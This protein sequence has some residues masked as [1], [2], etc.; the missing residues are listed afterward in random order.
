MATKDDPDTF[1]ILLATDNH[2][3]YMEKDPIRG[4]DSFN[5]FEEILKL[6]QERNADLILLG[7]DL[8]HDNKPSRKCLHSTMVLLRKY[9][10]GDRP[11]RVEFLSDQ[12]ENFPN[13][14]AT[15]NYQDPNY[16][17]SMP[18]YSIHGNHDDPSGD[19][20]LCALD[21]LSV[22][23]LVNYFGKQ[24]EVD[25]IA[26]KP[27]LL[28]KGTTRLALFGLGNVRDERLN[29]TFQKKK[30][31]MFRP[32]D[33]GNGNWFNLMV[34]H[35]NRV[36]H[37]PT[38]YIP[39]NFLEDFLDLIVWGHE[40]ECLVEPELNS[41]T[42]FYVTQPGSSVA[43]SLCEG[44]AVPKHVAMLKIKGDQFQL[45]KVRLKTVRPF[46]MDE[47]ILKD[48][49]NLRPTDQ[50][51]VNTFL[52]EKFGQVENLLERALND[53]SELNPNIPDDQWPKPLIRLKVEYSGG[54]TTFN[55][56]RFGQLFVNRVAN[57]K[58]ILHFYRKRANT[59]PAAKKKGDVKINVE[60]FMPEKLEEF[61]VED[62]VAECL[63]AQKLDILPENEFGDA[64]RQFVEKDEKDAIREYV[65]ECS[66]WNQGLTGEW[67]ILGDDQFRKEV[68]KEK[69]SRVEQF[70]VDK[71]NVS[72][73]DAFNR[74]RR[75]TG[76][77]DAQDEEVVLGDDV[78]GDEPAVTPAKGR[79][80][81][82]GG[83]SAATGRGRGRGR[84]AKAEPA[85]RS[86][87]KGRGK[88]TEAVDD[89]GDQAGLSRPR[90]GRAKAAPKKP[91]V[92]DDDDLGDNAL[93]EEDDY[94]PAVPNSRKRKAPASAAAT[95]NKRPAARNTSAKQTTLNFASQGGSS[96]QAIDVDDDDPF[97]DFTKPATASRSKAAR[98]RSGR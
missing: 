81:G 38:N 67:P 44:E 46:I 13:S 5:A 72:V 30:V 94:E 58:D 83:A 52:Q 71:T 59:V 55:P 96:A 90:S 20:S 92:I 6:G 2:V 56:Q 49:R 47:V 74:R 27:I 34:L 41:A 19:G 76:S 39:E 16:N 93:T 84:G 35:Q 45:E 66:G 3:G 54:F 79:G 75:H 61:R 88:Q 95:P 8:F 24:D 31:R 18:V 98:G 23:G 87:A 85:A 62:L 4:Q 43:T 12:S 11:C 28:Q 22:A 78:D 63:N 77:N 86:G 60:A 36:P 73:E 70:E 26:I 65:Y 9:C 29:R 50:K 48:E 21:I 14:F 37:G 10:M 25:D 57:P 97:S 51:A 7:G 80:R 32:R 64:V 69:Q 42:G 33:D 40:H 53:W 89:E 17:V 91:I 1:N 68:L 82:R 15:V